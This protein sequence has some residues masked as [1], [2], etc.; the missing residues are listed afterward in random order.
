MLP[1]NAARGEVVVT[2]GGKVI[3]TQDVV[4]TN[5]VPEANFIERLWDH[6]KR[7]FSRLF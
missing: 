4:A 5:A 1:P 6:I 2:L 3:A 7:F